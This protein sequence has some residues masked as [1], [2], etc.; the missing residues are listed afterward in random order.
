M[1]E[2]GHGCV[3][4]MTS[5]V[6]CSNEGSVKSFQFAETRAEGAALS[7]KS[8][9]SKALSGRAIGALRAS[10]TRAVTRHNG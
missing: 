9:S 1:F 6:L 7:S 2:R 3:S 8:E 5:S 10:D 4:T